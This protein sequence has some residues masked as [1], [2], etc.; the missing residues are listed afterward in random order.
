M[1]VITRLGKSHEIPLNPI[2]PPFSYGFPMV[3]TITDYTVA[4]G[5][6]DVV[7]PSTRTPQA[8]RPGWSRSKRIPGGKYGGFHRDADGKTIEKPLGK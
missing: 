5:G 1:L 3:F 7:E 4:V 8:W 2:K 6:L